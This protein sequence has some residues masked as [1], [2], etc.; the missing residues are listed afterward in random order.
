MRNTLDRHLHAL[1]YLLA[2]AAFLPACPAAAATPLPRARQEA[3]RAGQGPSH[4][5]ASLVVVLVVDQ[6]RGDL[7]GRYA[8]V[9]TGGLKRLLD[10]GLQFTNALHGHAATETSPGHAAI[11][12]G[13]FPSRAGIPA[14]TWREGDRPDLRLVENVIDMEESLTGLDGFP[15]AS[16]RVLL[17]PGLADWIRDVDQ[18]VRVVSVSGKARA[19]VLMAGKALGDVFWFDGRVGRFVTS[20]YY[21]DRNPLWLDRFNAEVMQAYRADSIWASTVPP[22]AEALSAADTAHFEGDGIH[23]YFPHRY[24]QERVS[25]KT[26]DFFLWFET[27]P[28]LDRA[29][30]QVARLAVEERG[31][32]QAEGRTDF[33]SVSLS[34]TDR[35][36]H[37]YG[38][39]SREQMD[40]L[41]RLDRE[42]GEFLGFL[43]DRIGKEGYVL[44]LTGDH[45]V[46][47]MPERLGK[48][49]RL[50]VDDRSLLSDAATHA[51]REARRSGRSDPGPFIARALASIPFVGPIFSH[52]DLRNG[53]AGDSMAV[54]FRHSL[55]PGRAGGLLS[56]YGVEM[57]WA[58]HI[59]DWG[60]PVGT[61]HG[62]P[63]RYDRWVP[64][65][66]MGSGIEGGRVEDPVMPLDLAPT[67]AALAGIPF[68][69]DLDGKPLIRQ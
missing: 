49:R 6:L 62:S 7:L 48:G 58:E 37:D 29:T 4:G 11:S 3:A 51:V 27:V 16:P 50:T 21:R 43:D 59:L 17:R 64:L 8:D 22:G 56:T 60:Y 35:V 41:L 44:G 47:T 39:L 53:E 13:V 61:T 57:W 30:L 32:G 26:D 28:A 18:E 20:S 67:L 1:V 23:T 10:E 38:P 31:M 65:I 2:A 12:T 52:P 63:Y 42:L 66:L 68:P 46:L 54:L 14:N 24:S 34:Q 15:G 45:G 36:G 9:F 5:E 69:D 55:Y 25:P 33:L 19:A 40:N